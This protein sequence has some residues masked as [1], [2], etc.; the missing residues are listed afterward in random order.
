MP[1]ITPVAGKYSGVYSAVSCGILTDD[2]FRLSMTP[3]AQEVRGTDA[4]AQTLLTC[5]YQGQDWRVIW[6]AKEWSAGAQKAFQ[7]FGEQAGG[8]SPRPKLGIIAR[9]FVDMAAALVLTATTG[10]PAAAAPASLTA[11]LAILSP[12]ANV[13]FELTSRVRE[14]PIE[15]LLLPYASGSDVIPFSTT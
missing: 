6:R 10:T 5:I 8:V 7:I 13:D 1:L 3:H 15:Q 4:F 9:D 2:G 11:S 12:N 14:V